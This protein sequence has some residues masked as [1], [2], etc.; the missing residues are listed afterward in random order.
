MMYAAKRINGKYVIESDRG[1]YI[2]SDDLYRIILRRDNKKI[3]N[4]EI[5]YL[6]RQYPKKIQL[7][8]NINAKEI[9]K[10]KKKESK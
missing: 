4:A 7:V 1:N 6:M 2:I 5:D 8:K 9:I 10:G 3:S